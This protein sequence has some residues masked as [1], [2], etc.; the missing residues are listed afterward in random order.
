MYKHNVSF[1]LSVY[2]TCTE[3]ENGTIVVIFVLLNIL[4]N[5]RNEKAT[6]KDVGGEKL[7]FNQTVIVVVLKVKVIEG[8][9]MRI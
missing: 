2:F 8:L 3:R 1:S 4:H 5:R 7:F 9:N 6:I